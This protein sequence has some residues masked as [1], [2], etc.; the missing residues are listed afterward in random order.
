MPPA[1]VK[2]VEARSELLKLHINSG[3]EPTSEKYMRL[4]QDTT[5]NILKQVASC[6]K[7]N[8]D[9]TVA[10]LSIVQQHTKEKPLFSEEQ[11]AAIRDSVTS[12]LD[13][14]MGANNSSNTVYQKIEE[15]ELWLTQELQDTMLATTA[16][17]DER[18]KTIQD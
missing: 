1:I 12:K 5:A 15:P 10:I 16:N 8:C 13:N 18:T 9:N 7:L 2:Y 17:L 6:G 4:A 11:V 3:L 14:T